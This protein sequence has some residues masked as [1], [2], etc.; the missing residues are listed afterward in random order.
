M[1]GPHLVL[2]LPVRVLVAGAAARHSLLTPLLLSLVL[3]ELVRVHGRVSSC[4]E[5]AAAAAA[6]WG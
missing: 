1:L 3:L 5:R 6:A 4:S 2:V